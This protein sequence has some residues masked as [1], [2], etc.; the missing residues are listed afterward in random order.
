MNVRNFGDRMASIDALREQFR[1]GVT[2]KH[3]PDFQVGDRVNFLLP[4]DTGK[5][6]IGIIE[7][8]REEG[9][10]AFIKVTDKWSLWAY[11]NYSTILIE[12][13]SLVVLDYQDIFLSIPTEQA[14]QP[15]LFSPEFEEYAR[16]IHLEAGYPEGTKF[17]V[18]Y[19]SGT[20]MAGITL[21]NRITT[22]CVTDKD[23]MKDSIEVHV[24][25]YVP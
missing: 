10:E 14:I 25:R 23:M 5:R 1:K 2:V 3:K 15:D 4:S 11:I 13:P 6:E 12:H 17:T 24:P 8:I 9:T 22:M 19:D 7:Q 18:G 20:I 16:R 21:P